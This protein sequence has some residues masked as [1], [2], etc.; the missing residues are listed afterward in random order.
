MSKAAMAVAAAWLVGWAGAVSTA[1]AVETRRPEIEVVFVLDTT[2][3]MGGM[4]QAAK[5]KIWSI[6]NEIA[7]GRPAPRVKMGLVAYRDKGDEYVTKVFDLTT[8]LDKT[9]QDLL[10]L[11][12]MGGGDE[13]EHVL[14]ALD[15]A[16]H[17]ISWSKDPKTFK[18]VYLVGDA[19]PHYDYHDTPPLEDIMKQAVTRGLVVNAI[20]CGDSALTRESWQRVARLGE[21]KY[22]DIPEN[23]GVAVVETP[24]DAR[25]AELN[26]KLEGSMLAFGAR[27][28]EAMHMALEGASLAAAAPAS[29]AAD[30]ALFKAKAGFSGEL[31]L[32]A[33]VDEKRVSL[34]A[35]PQAEL[36]DALRGLSKAELAARV[37]QV[38]EERRKVSAEMS[39][40][41]RKRAEYLAK[42]APKAP[43][44]GFDAKLVDSLREE[45][46]RKGIAY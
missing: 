40:V 27:K 5:D 37:A 29:A 18:V 23:G 3:S 12:A 38:S 44:G 1:G 10:T 32:A 43:E 24:F 13:P 41:E 26:R 35:V 22:L 28:K 2:G 30:R 8:N 36:P 9:Y 7:K 34:D 14:Q 15:D 21:G 42:N 33:A 11:Q 25:L 31:D 45:A 39:A 4:I 16:V 17:K 20:Q 6:A 19:E 46:G